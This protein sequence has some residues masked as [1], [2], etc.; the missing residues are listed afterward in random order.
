MPLIYS[1]SGAGLSSSLKSIANEM[2]RPGAYAVAKGLALCE[3][4]R[5]LD[6]SGCTLG[7]TR[8]FK[9]LK[10]NSKPNP[11]RDVRLRSALSRCGGP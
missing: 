9:I 7:G 11:K 3:S 1:V 6:L 8:G 5:I 4:I 2:G 10:P